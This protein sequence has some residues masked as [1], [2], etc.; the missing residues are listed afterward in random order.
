MCI[1]T[2]GGAEGGGRQYWRL[3]RLLFFNHHQVGPL[4]LQAGIQY[5]YIQWLCYEVPFYLVIKNEKKRV[6]IAHLYP[7]TIVKL[8]T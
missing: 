6:T 3:G 8:H 1:L 4:L 7:L 5:L 2:Q